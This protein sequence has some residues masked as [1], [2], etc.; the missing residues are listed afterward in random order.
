MKLYWKTKDGRVLLISKIPI[1]HLENIKGLLERTASRIISEE[2]SIGYEV[3]MT[4]RG[5]MATYYAVQAIHVWE[6]MTP[7]IFLKT[8][9]PQYEAVCYWLSRK[10][11]ALNS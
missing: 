10:Q 3:L 8:Y 1:Q 4:L 2:I 11:G 7:E 6:G 5:E 9:I